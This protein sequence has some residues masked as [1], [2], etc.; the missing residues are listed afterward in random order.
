MKRAKILGPLWYVAQ[1]AP[2]GSPA[3]KKHLT[4][5]GWPN[6]E[7]TL[8][9]P[10]TTRRPLQ[11][12]LAFPGYMFFQTSWGREALAAACRG[13]PGL[14]R[15][16]GTVDGLPIPL[17][18]G[19]FEQLTQML[20]ELETKKP[21]SHRLSPGALVEILHGPLVAMQ[22]VCLTSTQESVKLQVELMGRR[23]SLCIPRHHVQE[24]VTSST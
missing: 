1:L 8:R 10:A 22:G 6:H 11:E 3:A 15:V 19:I 5:L 14:I 9:R 4:Q 21:S 13:S 16:L 2:G 24:L 12:I 20:G 18:P 7:F 23:I 17:R